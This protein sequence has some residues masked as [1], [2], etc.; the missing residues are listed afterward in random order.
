MK[1]FAVHICH[2]QV[3]GCLGAQLLRAGASLQQPATANNHPALAAIHV[4]A[5]QVVHKWHLALS[6]IKVT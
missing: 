4:A 3:L 1:H 2:L 6:S 5:H